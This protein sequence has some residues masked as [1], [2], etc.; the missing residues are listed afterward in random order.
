[1]ARRVLLL[2]VTLIIILGGGYYFFGAHDKGG[3][4]TQ[5]MD[6][7]S[8]DPAAQELYQALQ[9]A[10]F[11]EQGSKTAAHSMYVIFD[12]NCIFCHALFAATQ[13]QV[14]A[15]NLAIRW[16][17]IGIIKRSSP[18]KTMAILSAKSPLEALKQNEDG[19]N[20]AKEEGGIT[21]V[22]NPTNK[23]I[24]QF[25]HNMTI[26]KGLINSVPVVVYKNAAGQARISGGALLPLKADNAA[27]TE[28][29]QKIDAFINSVAKSW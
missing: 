4:Q 1:M 23:Q 19:F 3:S 16:V 9:T 25:N 22:T 13:Q 2:L 28:N 27:L 17:P 12:P 15:G 10:N 5:K 26:L 6:L 21:P 7:N 18:L 29:E 20:Y 11:I 14:D 24:E 8:T